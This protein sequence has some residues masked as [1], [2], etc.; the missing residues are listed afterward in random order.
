M[1]E[2][3]IFWTYDIFRMEV[4]PA[5]VRASTFSKIFSSEIAWLIK[6]K[7]YMQHLWEVGDQ[8]VYKYSRS[9]DQEGRH[10]HICKN[11]SKIFFSDPVNLFQRNLA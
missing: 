7:N 5:S 3:S 11:P 10:V 1:Q 8:C 6:A 4:E 2:N 9:H